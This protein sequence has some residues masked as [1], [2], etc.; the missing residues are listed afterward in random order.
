MMGLGPYR[1]R[2]YARDLVYDICRKVV[3]TGRPLLDLLAENAEVTKHLDRAALERLCDPGNYLGE[4]GAV[5]DRVLAMR[6]T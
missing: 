1:G 3:A 4:A 5:V 2:P 6:G